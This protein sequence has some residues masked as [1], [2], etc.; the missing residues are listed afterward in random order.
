MISATKQSIR[1]REVADDVSIEK[2]ALL[3][4]GRD[5]KR[6]SVRIPVRPNNVIESDGNA[7][8]EIADVSNQQLFDARANDP[9]RFRPAQ[10]VSASAED[11]IHSA[12][13]DIVVIFWPRAFP[14][15]PTSSSWRLNIRESN[16]SGLLAFPPHS[17]AVGAAGWVGVQASR[18]SR[19]R[20][21]LLNASHL[22]HCAVS[23]W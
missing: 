9:A 7:A 6:S 15:P 4:K 13:I 23:Q 21:L 20:R 8:L 10:S 3:V 19:A 16:G 12:R 5:V 17:K 14:E 18:H 22:R 1:L 11:G 2:L